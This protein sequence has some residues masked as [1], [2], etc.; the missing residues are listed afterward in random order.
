MQDREAIPHQRLISRSH[1]EAKEEGQPSL[2]KN[3][4]N[5]RL[6]TNITDPE[7]TVAA[8]GEGERVS[9]YQKSC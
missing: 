3:G 5:R 6:R 9:K 8:V 7:T 2:F 1:L 4:N